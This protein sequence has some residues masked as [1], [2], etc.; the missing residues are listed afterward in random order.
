MASGQEQLTRELYLKQISEKGDRDLLIEVA[1]GL[2]DVKDSC[3][4][5]CG[6]ADNRKQ[7][8]FNATGVS[9]FVVA[10]IVGVLD[11]LGKRGN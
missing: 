2:Y 11:W 4:K 7:N 3:A 9:G 8:L 1:M 5:A 10:V 6:P